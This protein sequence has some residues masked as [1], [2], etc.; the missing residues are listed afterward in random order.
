[1][2]L[3]FSAILGASFFTITSLA[4]TSSDLKLRSDAVVQLLASDLSLQ[5]LNL[6]MQII[7]EQVTIHGSRE[8][9]HLTFSHEGAGKIEILMSGPLGF[10][11][12]QRK[13]PALFISAG[14]LSGKNSIKLIP[15]PQDKILVGYQYP[16]SPEE[17]Q[18]DPSQ[19]PKALRLV[20]GQIAL[21][22]EWLSQRSYIRA[23]RL[24]V[25]GISLG[26]LFLPVS[27]RLAQSRNIYPASTVLCFGG[28]DV[29]SVIDE[30]MDPK[31]ASWI[32]D[33]S[34]TLAKTVLSLHDPSLHLPFLRGPFLT[35]YATEDEVFPKSSSL[36]QYNLLSEP[37]RVH[38]VQGP[39]ISEKHPEMIFETIQ[40]VEK[41]IDQF[42]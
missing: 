37:K 1:M 12:S 19:F 9:H 16:T 2:R 24:H 23:D 28:A 39:H 10:T 5:D 35:V 38:W 26:T 30:M 33:L 27:L 25:M 3:L 13:Y 31:I 34:L 6:K 36:L 40:L 8:E 22:L 21:L 20:P 15:N 42:E 4:Q 29:L 11:N 17:I 14:F 7:D 32:R 41:F 18:K